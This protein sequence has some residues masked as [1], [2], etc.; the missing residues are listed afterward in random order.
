MHL[1]FSG[2]RAHS[3]LTDFFLRSLCFSPHKF[4]CQV[5]QWISIPFSIPSYFPNLP[6]PSLIERAESN[7][8]CDLKLMVYVYEFQLTLL[9]FIILFLYSRTYKFSLL[10]MVLKSKSS[11]LAFCVF[12]NQVLPYLSN[13]IYPFNPPYI[14]IFAFICLILH[15]I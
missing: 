11:H 2:K 10:S 9:T 8:V 1:H 3:S 6:P 5:L 12:H 13:V 14:F 15:A 4:K 7:K